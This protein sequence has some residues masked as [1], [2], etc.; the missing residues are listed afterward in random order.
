MVHIVPRMARRTQH[1]VY[2]PHPHPQNGSPHVSKFPLGRLNPIAF[3]STATVEGAHAHSHTPTC[4]ARCGSAEPMSHCYHASQQ[5]TVCTGDHLSAAVSYPCGS[6]P[7]LCRIEMHTRP[8]GYTAQEGVCTCMRRWEMGHAYRECA[9]NQTGR[10]TACCCATVQ[11][12][13]VQLPPPCVGLTIRVPHLASEAA[14]GWG[15][16]VVLGECQ[17]CIEE[18]PLTAA[19]AETGPR[20]SCV[21]HDPCCMGKD[22]QST[23]A[24]RSA[25]ATTAGPHAR[26]P[27]LT[28]GSPVARLL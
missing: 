24:S 23:R 26:V 15:V 22:K 17:A 5:L 21:P 28:R 13:L 18:A 9:R 3:K 6:L 14:C 7:G 16:G 4:R 1:T 19:Q 20:Q 12:G 8:S 11:C 10:K 2:N 25:V 27:R